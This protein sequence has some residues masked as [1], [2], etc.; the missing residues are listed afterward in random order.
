M[1]RLSVC[2]AATLL[3]SAG[4]VRTQGPAIQKLPVG[5]GAIG[6]GPDALTPPG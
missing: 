5:A 4:D 1:S 3:L 2:V 6:K